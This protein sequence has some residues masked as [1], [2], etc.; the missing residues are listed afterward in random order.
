M[1][2]K[3]ALC[4]GRLSPA[5]LPFPGMLR[6]MRGAGSPKSEPAPR[7]DPPPSCLGLSNTCMQVLGGAEGASGYGG[8]SDKSRQFLCYAE[9]RTDAQE[10]NVSGH[11]KTRG[12]LETPSQLP[13]K[14]HFLCMEGRERALKHPPVPRAGYFTGC[15]G[16]ISH[17][18][19]AEAG[20]AG[21]WDGPLGFWLVTQLVWVWHRESGCSVS[22]REVGEGG[23][24]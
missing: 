8:Y 11:P 18:S 13:L 20:E 12:F 23:A 10:L 15:P 7:P 2:T 1:T 21:D 22:V 5:F 24:I 6:T 16:F 9:H 4:S 3:S 19:G 14:I 17:F